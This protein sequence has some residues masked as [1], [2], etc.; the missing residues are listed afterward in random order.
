MKIEAAG[1]SET[2][3]PMYQHSV[4]QWWPTEQNVVTFVPLSKHHSVYARGKDEVKL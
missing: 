1:S 3:V 2:L 4:S